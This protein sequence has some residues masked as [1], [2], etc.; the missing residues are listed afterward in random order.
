MTFSPVIHPVSPAGVSSS[1]NAML[2]RTQIATCRNRCAPCRSELPSYRILVPRA[3]PTGRQNIV[4]VRRLLRL[5]LSPR[6]NCASEIYTSRFFG[7]S[8]CF[9]LLYCRSGL[10]RTRTRTRSR[11]P[12]RLALPVLQVAVIPGPSAAVK[13]RS[14]LALADEYLRIIGQKSRVFRRLICCAFE[15]SIFQ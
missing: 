4:P 12:G 11:L 6:R 13:F 14:D 8:A 15:K 3:P 5:F 1:M 7:C 9:P 10:A 2:A